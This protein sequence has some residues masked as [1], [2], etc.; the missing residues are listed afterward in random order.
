MHK[1]L[2]II[3]RNLIPVGS[4]LGVVNAI[5]YDLYFYLLSNSH[6]DDHV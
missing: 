3:A 6:A 2:S 4:P 5:K 1:Y